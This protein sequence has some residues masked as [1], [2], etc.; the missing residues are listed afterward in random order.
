MFLLI[1]GSIASI[2]STISL[3]PQLFQTF[4]TKSVSDLSLLMLIN[5]LICSL[6]WVVYGMII[7]AFSVWITNVI[8]LI[9]STLLIILKIKYD[10]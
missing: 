8:M 7:R 2:T 6:C 1:I 4:K 10:K 5:F 9:L 3:I